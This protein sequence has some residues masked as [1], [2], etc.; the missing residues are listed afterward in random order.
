MMNKASHSPHVATAETAAEARTLHSAF[1]KQAGLRPQETALIWDNGAITFGQLNEEANELAAVLKRMGVRPNMLVGLMTE[2]TKE[3][4]VGIL[5]VWKAGGAYVPIELD[6]PAERVRYML[7]DAGAPIVLTQRHLLNRLEEYAG[8]TVCMDAE[9]ENGA[10][11]DA[12]IAG[13]D[14]GENGRLQDDEPSQRLAYLIYTSGSTGKPKGVMIRHDHAL[15]FMEGMA[16]HVGF[17]PGK[18]I[19][20]LASAAFDVSI[21][22]LVMPLLYGMKVVLASGIQRRDPQGLNLLMARHGVQMIVTTPLRLQLLLGEADRS[23]MAGLTDIMVGGEPFPPTLWD[24]LK[25]FP[26]LRVFNVYGPT[27]TT[28]WSTVQRVTDG[29]PGIGKPLAGVKTY[30]LNEEG[31]LASPGDS[32]E[33]YIGGNRLG[34]GYWGNSE[35]TDKAFVRSPFV[36]GERIYKTGDLVRLLPDG[37]L[38]FLGRKDFQ[39]KIRGHR[40]ELEEVQAVLSSF[41]GMKEA[42]VLLKERTSGNEQLCAYYTA[43]EVFPAVDLRAFMANRLPEYMVPYRYIRLD[44]MPLTTNGKI[45]R[46]ALALIDTDAGDDGHEQCADMEDHSADL[47]TEHEKAVASLWQEVLDTGGFRASDSFFEVG[48]NSILLVT[49]YGKIEMAYPGRVTVADLFSNATVRGMAALLDAPEA[50]EGDL[51]DLSRMKGIVLPSK[52]EDAALE[53]TRFAAGCLDLTLDGTVAGQL[54]RAAARWDVGTPDILLSAYLYVLSDLGMT[55]E[56]SILVKG[57]ERDRMTP[58]ELSMTQFMDGDELV[59]EV[60]RQRNSSLYYSLDTLATAARF[61][62]PGRG[63]IP[64]FSLVDSSAADGFISH[65]GLALEFQADG[66]DIVLIC[67]YDTSHLGEEEMAEWLDVF[68]Q[69]LAILLEQLGEGGGGVDE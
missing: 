40:V 8:I 21:H 56:L 5:A 4:V 48:G 12:K 35:L 60:R 63:V 38:Q 39:V 45:D 17:E 33:L 41:D 14:N 62:A 47:E 16:E 51:R 53:K 32:G 43:Q 10:E 13:S 64:W 1:E 54:E 61:R 11:L 2:R 20:A 49:L 69:S 6:Y 7:K 25:D 65:I 46:P 42:A 34:V 66:N 44:V 57:S 18:T 50:E 27:E 36:P 59:R 19:A 52:E 3:L 55:D 31:G 23:G 15:S 29:N 67:Q 28:V 37:N 24:Q 26:N 9:V 68:R 30:V 22:D 58:V